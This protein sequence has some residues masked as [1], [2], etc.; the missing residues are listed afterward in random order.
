MSHRCLPPHRFRLNVSRGHLSSIGA[1]R[2]IHGD[3]FV[4]TGVTLA[5]NGTIYAEI[6]LVLGRSPG[7][8]GRP[9]LVLIEI[10]NEVLDMGDRRIVRVVRLPGVFVDKTMQILGRNRVSTIRIASRIVLRWSS[11]DVVVAGRP[12]GQE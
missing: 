1:L 5:L 9:R 6:L 8:A 2:N 12:D 11:R 3:A 7:V 10:G 4:T